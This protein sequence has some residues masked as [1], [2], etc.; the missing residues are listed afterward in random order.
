MVYAHFPDGQFSH[1]TPQVAVVAPDQFGHQYRPAGHDV[2][3][4][5]HNAL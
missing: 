2:N 3:P 5:E 1:E 4:F